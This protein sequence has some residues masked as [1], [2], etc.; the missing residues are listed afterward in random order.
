M[1]FSVWTVMISINITHYCRRLAF[2]KLCFDV[3][4]S[5]GYVYILVPVLLCVCTVT[6]VCACAFHKCPGKYIKYQ[7]LSVETLHN[8][9]AYLV[10]IV[11]DCGSLIH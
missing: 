3:H 8:R 10:F 11:A 5:A 4:H 6:C 7:N 9:N 2:L 1:R